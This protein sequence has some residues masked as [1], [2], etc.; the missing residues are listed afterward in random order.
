MIKLPLN[1]K[2]KLLNAKIIKFCFIVVITL[3]FTQ[4]L[5]MFLPFL[6]SDVLVINDY[7]NIPEETRIEGKYIDN[8]LVF[9]HYNP[10]IG[11][12]GLEKYF[13]SFKSAND[14]VVRNSQ[15]MVWQTQCGWFMH[16]HSSL[17]SGI[18]QLA[19]GKN[20]NE[21]NQ[22]YGILSTIT[23]TFFMKLFGGVTFDN[24][25]KVL[26]SFYPL[27][28]L[29]FFVV[30]FYL[31]KDVKYVF[32]AFLSAVSFLFQ[33]SFTSIYL[34]PGFNPIRQIFYLFVVLILFIYFERR[35]SYLLALLSLLSLLSIFN[36]KEFGIPILGALLV[37]FITYYL[38][39]K[40]ENRYSLIVFL[41]LT[42]VLS[43]FLVFFA[44]RSSNPLGKYYLMGLS[45]PLI[46]KSLLK[47]ILLS[48]IFV[49]VVILKLFA[50][51][52]KLKYIS[53][54]MFF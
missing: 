44:Q 30:I 40:K 11:F 21:I 35:H 25:I 47:F 23:L 19:L 4:I 26:Y 2:L 7:I 28:Y 10:E 50:K 49:Y 29:V 12:S 37:T 3:L 20:M 53:I 43:A 36:N 48:I 5:W 18:N 45:G 13:N 22:Q 9:M 1:F 27:F 51:N 33:L 34:A 32:L 39:E 15:E 17:L 38:F 24:Y 8:S 46:N 31:F 16:H 54:F 14:F 6:K 42:I 41:I 52:T